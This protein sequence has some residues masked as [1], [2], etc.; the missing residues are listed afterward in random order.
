M[1][2]VEKPDPEKHGNAV[3]SV[4]ENVTHE[5]DASS[6]PG[7][8]DQE[9]PINRPGVSTNQAPG[10]IAQSLVAGAGAPQVPPDAEPL[11]E[12]QKAESAPLTSEQ[13][14]KAEPAPSSKKDDK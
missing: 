2:D 8:Y 11:P 6:A 4:T 9:M 3:T 1:A 13:K 12:D 5:A 14:A 7:P 10:E